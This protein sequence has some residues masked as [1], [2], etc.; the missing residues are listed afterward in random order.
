MGLEMTS[1]RASS[2]SLWSCSCS[3]MKMNCLPGVVMAMPQFHLPGRLR[4]VGDLKAVGVAYLLWLERYAQVLHVNHSFG[5]LGLCSGGGQELYLYERVL[6]VIQAYGLDSADRRQVAHGQQL[7]A[8][9][10]LQH[11][12]NDNTFNDL[13]IKLWTMLVARRLVSFIQRGSNSGQCGLFRRPHGGFPELEPRYLQC[14]CCWRSRIP[15]AGFETLRAPLG[16]TLPC[17]DLDLDHDISLDTCYTSDQREA[18][19]RT[20]NTATEAELAGVKLLRGRRSANVVDYRTKHGPFTSL[21][22]VVKVPLL[23]HKTALVVFNAILNPPKKEKKVKVQL[24]K[25]IKPEVDRAW[26]EEASSIVSIICGTNK[27]A[28]AH[29]DR[30]MMISNV[31]SQLPSADFYLVEKPSISLQNTTLF[32]IMAHMRSVEAMLFALLEPSVY[33]TDSNTPPRGRW[34]NCLYTDTFKV[35]VAAADKHEAYYVLI[36]VLNMMRLAV[37]RHFS[38]MVGESRTSGAQAVRQM[39]TESVTQKMPRLNFPQDLLLKYRNAFQMGR[40]RGGEELCD[41]LL[42]AVAFYELLNESSS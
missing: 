39:M 35:K 4:P 10:K 37:G 32:P 7:G 27:V 6:P 20:L 11:V 18:I 9:A 34:G 19:L 22:A 17:K 28:W 2:H 15:V 8:K 40:G 21:E 29:V 14:T 41:A 42:Q 1:R 30:G 13:Y 33:Q 26:L 5:N 23:K 24:M 36:R 31:V 12:V 16:P 25:F 3:H 38:L